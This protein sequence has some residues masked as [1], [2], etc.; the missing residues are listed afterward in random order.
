MKYIDLSAHL[1]EQTPVYPGDPKVK[2]EPVAEVAADGC[3]LTMLSVL[4]HVGTHIDAPAH[5]LESGKTLDQFPVDHFVGR[6]RLVVLQNKTYDLDAVKAA[7][8]EA[9]DIVLFKTGMASHSQEP[10]YFNN[11]PAMPEAVAAYLAEQKVKMVGIDAYSPDH[12]EFV[13]HKLLLGADVLIIENLTNLEVLEGKTFTVYALPL[14]LA[15]DG[16][17]ARVIAELA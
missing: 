2:L 12:E 9:G 10:G 8:I 5:M 7:G 1:N 6:G 4:T 3:R 13:T 11:Y 15:V 17:P 16:A 14:K